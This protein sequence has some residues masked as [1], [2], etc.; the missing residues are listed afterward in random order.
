MLST[1]TDL[2]SSPETTESSVNALDAD[3]PDIAEVV[4]EDSNNEVAQSYSRRSFLTLATASALTFTW[5]IGVGYLLWGR[6]VPAP[7]QS[8]APSPVP[9]TTQTAQT[10]P[11]S[12]ELPVTYSQL[13]PWMINAGAFTYDAFVQVYDQAG[14][15][16][17]EEQRAILQNGSDTPITIDHSNAYFLLNFFWALGLINSNP[18]LVSGALV[19]NSGGQIASYASTGG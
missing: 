7:V 13:G 11:H 3:A 5:G 16:L 1:S 2:N 12:V 15:P 17:S 18:I 9:T 6:T 8:S 14:Q 4:S 19:A 10:L